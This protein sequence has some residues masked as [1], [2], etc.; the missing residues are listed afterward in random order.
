VNPLKNRII[1]VNGPPEGYYV[2]NLSKRIDSSE[3]KVKKYQPDDIES[4]KALEEANL[5]IAFPGKIIIYNLTR[6]KHNR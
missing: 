5:L 3:F 1:T 4:K 6:N 2:S